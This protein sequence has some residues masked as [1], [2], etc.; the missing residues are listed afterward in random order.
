MIGARRVPIARSPRTSMLGT[1]GGNAA[2]VL[3][4][5]SGFLLAGLALLHVP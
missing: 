2:R 1:A 5:L 4:E 3:L